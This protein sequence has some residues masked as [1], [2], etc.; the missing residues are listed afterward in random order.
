MTDTLVRRDGGRI[1][2]PCM[3]VLATAL[4][5][6]GI[7]SAAHAAGDPYDACLS[8]AQSDPAGALAQATNW[9]KQGGGAAAD[10]CAALALIGLSR[11]SDAASRLD[12]LARSPFAA[13]PSRKTALFDQ[14]GN[15][16]LLAGRAD[17]AIAS[18]SAA[19]GVDPFDADLLADRARALALKQ[20]WAKADSDL[21]AALLVSPDR[22]DLYVLRGSARH[23]MGRKPD[24]RSD[25]DRAIRLQP[26]NA[27]AL[28]ERGTMKFEAGDTAGARADWQAALASSPGSLAAQTAQQR[29]TDI[30][31]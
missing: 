1:L 5:L 16:W 15:A 3:K 10:H 18:F 6:C 24:A 20:N 23:A 26:G 19:L 14:A 11:F 8:R 12:A 27:D 13:D 9:S 31:H 29:L 4:V 28:V 22:A 25:F 21:S 30:A 2:Y 17:S 7:A